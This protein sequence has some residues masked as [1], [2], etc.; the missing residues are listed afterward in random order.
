[1]TISFFVELSKSMD[2][3][4]YKSRLNQRCDF[5]KSQDYKDIRTNYQNT[6]ELFEDSEF[7]AGPNIL[8]N[9]AE[10]STIKI[11]YMGQTY[12]RRTEIEWLRP[13]VSIAKNVHYLNNNQGNL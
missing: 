7:V 5:I 6:K 12:I 10:G 8:T 2:Q 11:N 3:E 13:H 9:D 1:M 4:L